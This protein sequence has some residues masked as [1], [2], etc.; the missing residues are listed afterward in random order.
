VKHDVWL[1]LRG[2]L[3]DFTNLI[4]TARLSISYSKEIVILI[5]ECGFV[6]FE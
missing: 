3:I 1:D 2:S 4:I 6:D 5:N